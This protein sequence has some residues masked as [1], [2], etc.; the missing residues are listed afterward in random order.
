MP[1]RKICFNPGCGDKSCF[2]F[3][4]PILNPKKTSK[5]KN[6]DESSEKKN[7]AV[8]PKSSSESNQSVSSASF[9]KSKKL[10]HSKSKSS[11]SS[12]S[13]DSDS[14]SVDSLF[15]SSSSTSSTTSSSSEQIVPNLVQSK[16]KQKVFTPLQS[17]NE[18]NDEEIVIIGCEDPNCMD[19]NCNAQLVQSRN[20]CTDPNCIDANCITSANSKLTQSSCTDPSCSGCANGHDSSVRNAFLGIAG[21]LLLAM[22]SYLTFIKMK[23]KRARTPTNKSYLPT[24]TIKE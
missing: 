7:T 11:A 6:L 4:E 5:N 1:F 8:P 14:S 9:E 17:G 23:A 20:T 12:S 13:S 16:K 10:K 15:S 3:C 22:I 24:H 21:V 19:S 2:Q 18:D